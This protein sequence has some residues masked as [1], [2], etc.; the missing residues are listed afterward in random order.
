[1]ISSNKLWNTLKTYKQQKLILIT[2]SRLVQL[3]K[4]LLKESEAVSCGILEWEVNKRDVPSFWKTERCTQL[5]HD[6]TKMR[7]WEAISSGGKKL[8]EAELQAQIPEL[9]EL[10]WGRCYSW[11][12]LRLL[13]LWSTAVRALK[14]QQAVEKSELLCLRYQQCIRPRTCYI[15]EPHQ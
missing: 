5:Y 2:S 11:H 3:A 7:E 1:M 13:L 10:G 12:G 14:T 8:G 9:G 6:M 15:G 4:K